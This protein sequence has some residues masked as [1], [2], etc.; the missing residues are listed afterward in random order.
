MMQEN[1]FV[2]INRLG[3]IGRI[4]EY[5]RGDSTCWVQIESDD[6][7]EWGPDA[8][9]FQITDL[10]ELHEAKQEKAKDN[11]EK[12][13]AILFK[14]YSCIGSSRNPT[15]AILERKGA[16]Q[17]TLY[18][19]FDGLNERILLSQKDSEK[20]KRICKQAKTYRWLKKCHEQSDYGICDGTEWQLVVFSGLYWYEISDSNSEPYMLR[21]LFCYLEELGLPVTWEKGVGP[22]LIE[23]AETDI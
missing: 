17:V 1:Q 19:Y 16:L 7:F 11:S 6:Q 12:F 13:H 2:I 18:S 21:D 22:M 23:S 5:N 9:E 14:S 10:T 3:E 15:L 4:I 8:D 20:L